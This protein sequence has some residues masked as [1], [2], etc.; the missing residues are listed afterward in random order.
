MTSSIAHT[1]TSRH[2]CVEDCDTGPGIGDKRRGKSQSGEEA[3]LTVTIR[4][5]TQWSGQSFSNPWFPLGDSH[6]EFPRFCD[7]FHL[8]GVLN[9]ILTAHMCPQ[10]RD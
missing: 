5:R 7:R 3:R 6:R 1:L 2:G 9:F 4:P 10:W 8:R